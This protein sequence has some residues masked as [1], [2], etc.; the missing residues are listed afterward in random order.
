MKLGRKER[1]I[2]YHCAV[3]RDLN[4]RRARSVLSTLGHTTLAGFLDA[5]TLEE[6]AAGSIFGAVDLPD[7]FGNKT[8]YK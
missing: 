3:S 4:D 8:N 6:E 5:G 7:M 1:E 2:T